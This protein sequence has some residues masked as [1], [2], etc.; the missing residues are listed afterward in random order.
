MNQTTRNMQPVIT[1]LGKDGSG[2]LVPSHYAVRVGTST[3]C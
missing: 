3:S 2:E 1:K